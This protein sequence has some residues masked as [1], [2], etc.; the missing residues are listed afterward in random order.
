MLDSD[1]S[2][3]NNVSEHVY[4]WCVHVRV[5]VVSLIY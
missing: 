5:D 2:D 4:I 1:V 3:R